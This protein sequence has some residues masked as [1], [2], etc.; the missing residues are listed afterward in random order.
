[1]Y[2]AVALATHNEDAMLYSWEYQGFCYEN[3]NQPQKAIGSYANAWE[4]LQARH[5]DKSARAASVLYHLGLYYGMAGDWKKAQYW[6]EQAW[7]VAEELP[8]NADL[9]KSK[10]YMLYTFGGCQAHAGNHARAAAFYE[11]AMSNFAQFDEAF[12]QRCYQLAVSERRAAAD[13][14]ARH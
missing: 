14:P 11:R 8:D 4:L 12:K 6:A 3:M 9:I 10:A 5:L 2:M 13:K 1:M 7:E